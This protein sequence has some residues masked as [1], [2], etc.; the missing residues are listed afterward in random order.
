MTGGRSH[1]PGVML[2]PERLQ[3]NV[4]T[5]ELRIQDWHDGASLI[6]LQYIL[7]I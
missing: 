1:Q 3:A 5:A 7:L 4:L 2:L 6:M